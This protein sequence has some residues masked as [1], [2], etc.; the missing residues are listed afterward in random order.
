MIRMIVILK[1]PGVLE[2]DKDIDT[3]VMGDHK[4]QRVM[5]L[6]CL[7]IPRCI[8]LRRQVTIATR[9]VA[10]RRVAGPISRA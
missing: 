7:V 2:T 5:E 8:I 6:I 3:M 10:G 4:L 1:L 9:N